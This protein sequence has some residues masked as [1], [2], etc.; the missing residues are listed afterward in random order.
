MSLPSAS[1]MSLI[2]PPDILLISVFL[3]CSLLINLLLV[4]PL[5]LWLTFVEVLLSIVMLSEDSQDLHSSC[6][7]KRYYVTLLL[8]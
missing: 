1:C 4:L 8:S 5:D 2:C 6:R 7:P 3:L